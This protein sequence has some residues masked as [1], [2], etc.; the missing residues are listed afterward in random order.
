LRTRLRVKV[1]RR[2]VTSHGDPA[3]ADVVVVAKQ[4]QPPPPWK[5]AS[6]HGQHA[7][8]EWLRQPDRQRRRQAGMQ[9]DRQTGRQAGWRTGE[10][11][12]AQLAR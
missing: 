1:G 5:R 8:D 6:V 3:F 2:E 4:L 9:A 7:V 10:V 12:M 11:Q